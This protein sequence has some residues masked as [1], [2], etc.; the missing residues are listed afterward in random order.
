MGQLPVSHQKGMI[1]LMEAADRAA[2]SIRL[3]VF[4]QLFR[5]SPRR[6]ASPWLA[7]GV[8]SLSTQSVP[9][10]AGG[11]RLAEPGAYGL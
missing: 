6:R 11:L 2:A 1:T 10:R 5:S 7:E 9:A 4:E 3:I 8:W